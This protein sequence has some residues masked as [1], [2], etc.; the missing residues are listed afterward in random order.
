MPSAQDRHWAVSAMQ[1]TRAFWSAA[2]TLA[3][4][5]DAAG[6]MLLLNVVVLALV[7]TVVVLGLDVLATRVGFLAVVAP[8]GVEGCARGSGKF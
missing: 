7:T 6:A 1:Q 4:F 8:L 3:E 5:F 2:L